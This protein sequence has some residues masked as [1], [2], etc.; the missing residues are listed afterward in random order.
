LLTGGFLRIS[1]LTQKG[2]TN[3]P[4][5]GPVCDTCVDGPLQLRPAI[6]GFS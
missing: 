4:R 5:S 2:F 6:M 1:S 3:V